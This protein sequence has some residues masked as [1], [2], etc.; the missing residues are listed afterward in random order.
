MTRFEVCL[1]AIRPWFFF[2]MNSDSKSAPLCT[3][4]ANS[5][6]PML[7][8]FLCLPVSRL[9]SVVVS[10]WDV[11]ILF[12]RILISRKWLNEISKC[13]AANLDKIWWFSNKTF[14]KIDQVS[15]DSSIFHLVHCCW[16]RLYRRNMQFQLFANLLPLY[17]CSLRLLVVS[18]ITG[19]VERVLH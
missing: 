16:S 18:E 12:R 6:M 2:A 19:A 3:I 13:T 4:E 8:F 17:T 1:I 11:I 14:R 5:I 7:E 15:Q 10:E 9:F